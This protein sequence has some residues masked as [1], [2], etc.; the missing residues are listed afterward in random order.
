MRRVFAGKFHRPAHST[1]AA[2][3]HRGEK[4]PRAQLAEHGRSALV[5][6]SQSSVGYANSTVPWSSQ[7][8]P[9]GWCKW[10]PTK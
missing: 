9:W 10:P 6:G 7:W 2:R 3:R 8:L 1:L 5:A 4:R